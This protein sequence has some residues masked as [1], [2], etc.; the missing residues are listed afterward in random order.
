VVILDIFFDHFKRDIDVWETLAKV[1]DLLRREF[2]VRGLNLIIN[3]PLPLRVDEEVAQWIVQ[4][5]FCGL[6]IMLREDMP[7]RGNLGYGSVQKDKN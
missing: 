5:R 3:L 2:T 4:Y 6:A 7:A 1:P